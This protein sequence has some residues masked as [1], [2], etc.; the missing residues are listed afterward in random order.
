[1]LKKLTYTVHSCQSTKQTVAE[2]DELEHLTKQ[3]IMTTLQKNRCIIFD[4][5]DQK[6]H[7]R[8]GEKIAS[9]QLFLSCVN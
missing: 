3:A 1:M 5:F 8:V 7:E 6:M 9:V 4:I 2:H